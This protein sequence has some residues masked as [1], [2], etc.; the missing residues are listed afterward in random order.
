MAT[1]HARIHQLLKQFTKKLLMKPI[2][3]TEGLRV[4]LINPGDNGPRVNLYSPQAS[5]LFY[6]KNV[7]FPDQDCVIRIAYG[8]TAA[9]MSTG[10]HPTEFE[11]R[12]FDD[13]P[14]EI[15]KAIEAF[16]L[17]HLGLVKVISSFEM[18]L[19]M[20]NSVTGLP[21]S[22]ECCN[23]H[24]DLG[25]K[26]NGEPRT[27]TADPSSPALIYTVGGNRNL[28]F[29]WCKKSLGGS[30][31]L[32]NFKDTNF[33]QKDGSL[34]VVHPDDDKPRT[35]HGLPVSNLFKTQHCV[36]R[37]NDGISV[38]C[39]FRNV[40]GQALFDRK[41]NLLI[42]SKKMLQKMESTNITWRGINPIKTLT[43]N[44]AF[45]EQQ[46]QLILFRSNKVPKIEKNI[47]EYFESEKK[48]HL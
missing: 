3:S 4:C 5:W 18:K 15:V 19:Y 14:Y 32:N 33:L 29:R 20:S 42:P 34:F 31:A 21:V 40:I 22:Q 38:A 1:D 26:D 37:C 10:F 35:I 48:W 46:A 24:N 13:C 11:V 43:R 41:T 12:P 2:G 7:C 45:K 25:F 30:W 28:L 8:V 36:Q 39:I 44:A 9:S 6:G 27:N 47:I 17:E 16:A 23:F